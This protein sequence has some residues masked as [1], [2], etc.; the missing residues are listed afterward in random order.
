MNFICLS[1]AKLILKRSCKRRPCLFLGGSIQDCRNEAGVSR[2]AAEM[3]FNCF[4]NLS[5]R[6]LCI[7][8]QQSRGCD[9]E[10]WSAEAA[11]YGMVLSERL[12]QPRQLIRKTLKRCHNSSRCLYGQHET[13]TH[14]FAVHEHAARPAISFAAGDRRAQ[15]EAFTK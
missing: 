12:L 8:A 14:G 6:R 10:P 9:H 7:A 13:G 15:S 1:P 2:T 5:F 11:L 4:A 3:P